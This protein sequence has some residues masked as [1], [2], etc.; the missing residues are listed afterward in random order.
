MYPLRYLTVRVV[1]RLVHEYLIKILM[2]VEYKGSGE[3]L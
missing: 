2:P 1:V 3:V